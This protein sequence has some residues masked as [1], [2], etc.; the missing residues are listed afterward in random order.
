MSRTVKAVDDV[1]A[2]GFRDG[3]AEAFCAAAAEIEAT[4]C[5]CRSHLKN[6]FDSDGKIVRVH[7]IF[8]PIALA[9]RL[10]GLA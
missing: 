1:Y 9:A 2:D 7:D 8:C 5:K 6:G 4:G 3:R 10:R